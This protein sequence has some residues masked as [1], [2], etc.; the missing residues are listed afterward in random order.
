VTLYS[1]QNWLLI[2]PSSN[3]LS[4]LPSE[5]KIFYGREPELTAILQSFAQETPRIAIVGA[6][7][8]GKTSLSRAVLHHPDIT[9]RY[10][11]HRF[12]VACDTVSSSLELAGLIGAHIG[13]NL[14][15]DL[16]GP[17]VQYFSSNP[18]AMLILDNLETVWEPA[19]SRGDVEKLLALLAG[20]V[21]LALIVSTNA[22]ALQPTLNF[23][24][25]HNT[26]CRKA[27]HCSLDTAI[28]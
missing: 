8:M 28:S 19:E 20:V 24:L 2:F 6:G 3:S 13:L 21:H 12:F 10:E 26:R 27:C 15:N 22:H 7:G 5:P 9:A 16:T 17:V 25:D 18:P 14:G 11:Q 4:L 1:I 23:V